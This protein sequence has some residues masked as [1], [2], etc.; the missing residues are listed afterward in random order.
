MIFLNDYFFKFCSSLL[1]FYNVSVV[2][3][4]ELQQRLKK[5][6]SKLTNE[7]VQ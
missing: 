3:S 4:I 7:T 1:F 5:K 2:D 6:F